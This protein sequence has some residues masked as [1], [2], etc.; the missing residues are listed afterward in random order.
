[1]S[2]TLPESLEF[3]AT[4]MPERTGPGR[5]RKPN[6]FMEIVAESK[7]KDEAYAFTLSGAT[8]D[9]G[10]VVK[11]AV[12]ALRRAGREHGYSVRIAVSEPNSRGQ[13]QVRFQAVDKIS[14]KPS[15]KENA[16]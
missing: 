12:N 4:K 16:A 9:D 3:T 2:T 8:K 15:N 7:A 11:E 10:A 1:M 5:E 6:P 13:V 14:R